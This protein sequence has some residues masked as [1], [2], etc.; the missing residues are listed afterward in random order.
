[1]VCYEG[2]KEYFLKGKVRNGDS[3]GWPVEFVYDNGF[4]MSVGKL[5]DTSGLLLT[6]SEVAATIKD[7]KLYTELVEDTNAQ[8]ALY[9]DEIKKLRSENDS[10]KDAV[11]VLKEQKKGLEN[12]ID[13]HETAIEER[14]IECNRW[15]GMYDKASKKCDELQK[16]CEEDTTV[17]I[18]L[19]NQRDN[20]KGKYEA[21]LKDLAQKDE[22]CEKL[23]RQW[24]DALKDKGDLQKAVDGLNKDIDGYR[25]TILKMSDVIGFL[26]GTEGGKNG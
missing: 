7:N 15:E 9:K 20:L 18:D 8:V 22:A 13:K 1:M 23:K 10:L 19:A 14:T 3:P 12:T 26:C 6:A 21:A 2:G 11:E 24:D 4:G 25:E 16:T 5:T 17:A